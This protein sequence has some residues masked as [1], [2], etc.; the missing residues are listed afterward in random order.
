[1]PLYVLQ[2]VHCKT[3]NEFLIGLSEIPKPNSKKEINLKS[4]N[5]KCEKCGKNIFKKMVTAHG[6]TASNWASWQNPPP[7]STAK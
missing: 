1:M 7:K 4:L 2:C 5:M 3:E 6:K